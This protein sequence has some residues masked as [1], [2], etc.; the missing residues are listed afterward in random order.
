MSETARNHFKQMSV[1]TWPRAPFKYGDLSGKQ[2]A[3]DG[4][5]AN[6]TIQ[7]LSNDPLGSG[8]I[9]VKAD[10][11]GCGASG[12]GRVHKSPPLSEEA[13]FFPLAIRIKIQSQLSHCGSLQNVKVIIQ[14]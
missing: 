13:I 14:S 12:Q 4:P 10:Q 1:W 6:V 3:R 9:G 7:G 5:A 8:V 2:A 11:R